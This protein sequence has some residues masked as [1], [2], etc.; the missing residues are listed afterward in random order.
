[1]RQLAAVWIL[2]GLVMAVAALPYAWRSTIPSPFSLLGIAA[3]IVLVGAFVWTAAQAW[4]RGSR[5]A[6]YGLGLLM[7]GWATLFF[8][9]GVVLVAVG[10]VLFPL[11]VIRAKVIEPTALAIAGAL[12]AAALSMS[13][14]THSQLIWIEI[15][16]FAPIAAGLGVA[17]RDKQRR[18]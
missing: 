3:E 6:A 2:G 4:A 12:L 14:A 18:S 8:A 17:V 5:L 7:V 10:L 16:A 13:I 1:V 9:I 15:A 11:G